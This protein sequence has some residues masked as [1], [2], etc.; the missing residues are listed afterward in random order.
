[1]Y[2]AISSL[3][4]MDYIKKNGF[5]TRGKIVSYQYDGNGHKMPVIEFKT[6]EG[7]LITKKPFYYASTDLSIFKNYDGNINKNV[8]IIYSPKN[9]ENFVIE[10]E[11][12]FNLGNVIFTI[13]SSLFFLGIAIAEILGIITIEM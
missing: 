1:M 10:S 8:D 11:K 3:L 9:P 5:K 7:K 12:N 4:F 13:I 2:L 6:L